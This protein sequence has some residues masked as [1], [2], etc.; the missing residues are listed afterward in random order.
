M[1]E[2]ES[3]KGV[4]ARLRPQHGNLRMWQIGMLLTFFVVWHILTVPGI[5]PPWYFDDPHKAPFFFGEPLKVM[6]RVWEWFSSGSI[7][8]H[9]W[10]TLWETILAF[11]IGTLSGLVIGL[12]LALNPIAWPT[13][14]RE[15]LAPEV[16]APRD[17]RSEDRPLSN[18]ALRSVG[19]WR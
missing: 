13:R 16:S 18:S 3:S 12:W 11:V 6:S 2:P 19:A 14:R 15:S 8:E 5:L 10:V 17:G 9:L 1:R 7:Y 4:W